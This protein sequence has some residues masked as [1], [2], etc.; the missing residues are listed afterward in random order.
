[1]QTIVFDVKGSYGHF[2]K[3]YAPVSPVT[4]PF[5]PPP[6]VLG[7]IGAICG[8]GKEDFHQIIGWE[9]TKIAATLRSPVRL[10]RAA[11]N[12]LNT[13]DGTDKH[14]I[15]RGDT[16]HMQIPFEFLRMPSFRLYVTGLSKRVESDLLKHLRTGTTAYTPCLGL[17][18]CIA[19][20][21]YVGEFAARN[22][23]SDKPVSCASVIPW[24]DRIVVKYDEGRH[25]QRF[26]IPAVMDNKRMV[27]RYQEVVLAE[28]GGPLEVKGVNMYEVGSE[29]IAFL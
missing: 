7:L 29:T 25:F 24:N 1:M 28:D 15:P 21:A 6:S 26:R 9:K 2:R 27:H 11:V 20:T 3:P 12:L 4:Y 17:A 10:F 13:D 23:D 18:N 19:D 22:I 14:F 5:P 8:Y 16:Y